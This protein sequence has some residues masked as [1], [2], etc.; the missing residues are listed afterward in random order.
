MPPALPLWLLLPAL[1]INASAPSTSS[2]YSC[3]SLTYRPQFFELMCSFTYPRCYLVWPLANRPFWPMLFLQLLVQLPCI[4]PAYT[5]SFSSFLYQF[6]A[7]RHFRP[8]YVMLLQTY[9]GCHV[10]SCIILRGRS[11]FNYFTGMKPIQ[12]FPG[13]AAY[14]LYLRLI[15]PADRLPLGCLF[16]PL[17]G[18]LP[19]Y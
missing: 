12:I 13:D 14:K 8:C 6:W 10:P 3:R 2:I 19:I 9:F 5:S 1:Y 7:S 16:D 17:Q 15:Q 11:L 4:W 18:T